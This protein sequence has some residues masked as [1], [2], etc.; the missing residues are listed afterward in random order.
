MKGRGKDGG[1][2]STAELFSFGFTFRSVSYFRRSRILLVS[3]FR[4]VSRVS[5]HKKVKRGLARAGAYREHGSTF[6]SVSH[7]RQVSNFRRSRTFPFSSVSHS[8][9][10]EF[11]SVAYCHGSRTSVGLVFLSVPHYR[12]SRT[13][14]SFT[15]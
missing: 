13:F 14:V 10:P 6:S 11:A 4:S 8:V 1:V 15:L 5:S 2:Y 7:F 12:R 3:T 9:G